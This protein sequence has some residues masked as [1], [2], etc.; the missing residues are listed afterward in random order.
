M[1]A[2]TGP[3]GYG[4]DPAVAAYAVTPSD[5]VDLV[6]GAC[7]ALYIGVT[8]DVS[9][10]TPQTGQNGNTSA[11]VILKACPVGTLPIGCS[12]VNATGTTAASLVALY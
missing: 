8:G 11:A 6:N 2:R 5:T 3:T 12:R 1:V 9:I 10:Q 7:R 4:A